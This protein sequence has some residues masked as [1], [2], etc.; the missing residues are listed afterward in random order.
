[1]FKCTGK[2]SE[3]RR[4]TKYITEKVKFQG[5][6]DGFIREFEKNPLTDDK[7][8]F[9]VAID[10]GTTTVAGYLYK[11]PECELLNTICIPNSQVIY[12]ADVI[13][14]IEHSNNGGLFDLHSKVWEQIWR[15][16]LS[17]ELQTEE[18][19]ELMVIT[20]NTAMLHMLLNIDPRTL[21]VAPFTPQSLFGWWTENAY[22]PK[23]ISSYV[24][25]DITTGIL[26]SGMVDDS[27]SFLVDIGTNGEMALWNGEK[28]ICCSTAAG[29]AFEGA[30]IAAGC[31][32][33]TG[34]INKVYIENGA[35]AYTTI[36]NAPAVGICGTGLI[37]VIA[38]MIE[39]GIIDE[40]GYMEE[41]FL[42]ADSGISITPDDIRQ[43]QL[44]KSAIRAGIDTLLNECGKTSADIKNFYIAGGF[45][46]YID[47]QSCAKIGLIP[48]DVLG[49]VVILG[50]AAGIGAGMILQSKECL[51]Q[52]E[53]IGITAETVELSTSPYFMTKYVDNMMFEV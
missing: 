21:A 34:A 37:D 4:C 28:L 7:D 1:M 42:I 17:F 24:G 53:Q 39:L 20:G 33:V 5:V 22:F 29:P 45:G 41:D 19:V 13:T 49:K 26:A 9:G 52:S 25:A 32:A 23:C 12:G 16:R 43:V 3:C 48:S 15:I 30:G 31:P 51:E 35:I 14:R 40:T 38:C 27:C 46:N 6:T 2:C 50:N 18:K 36:S 10:I 11:L 8:C 44:A 47:K